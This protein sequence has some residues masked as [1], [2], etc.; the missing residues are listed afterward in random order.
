MSFLSSAP[1]ENPVIVE[2]KIPAPV[3]KVYGAW[4]NPEEIVHWFGLNAGAMLSAE[5]DLQVGGAWRFLMSE[6]DTAVNYLQGNYLTIE[7]EECLSFTWQHVVL[8][9]EGG[10]EEETDISTVTITFR[11]D[12]DETYLHLCHEG[13]VK[14]DG[15][16]GVGKGW[17]ATL[18]NLSDWL[19]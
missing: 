13:I 7:P 14:P 5:I 2:G 10:V 1:G 4:T 16:L 19:Q 15:R 18:G 11:D 12:G 6:S 3:S 8:G 17:N 9:C